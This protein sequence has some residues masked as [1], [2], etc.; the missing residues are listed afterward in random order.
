MALWA[1]SISCGL[2]HAKLKI[3]SLQLIIFLNAEQETNKDS[4]PLGNV[5]IR[6]VAMLT[7]LPVL[8]AEIAA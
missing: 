1:N 7:F 5:G 3:V 6:V 2:Q 4:H 8:L